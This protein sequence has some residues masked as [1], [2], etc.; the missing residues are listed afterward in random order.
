MRILNL[1]KLTGH[2]ASTVTFSGYPPHGG[3][4]DYVVP[5]DDYYNPGY[6]G[7]MY[8]GKMYGGS[9]GYGGKMYGGSPGYGGKMY[10][11]GSGY[12]PGYGGKMYGG[13]YVVDYRKFFLSKT[14]F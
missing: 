2:H 1:C 8:G 9:P 10:G 5:T 7:K 13:E 11:S 6:G 4:D 12:Y 14:S 3:T